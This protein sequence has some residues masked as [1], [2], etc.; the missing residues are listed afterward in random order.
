MKSTKKILAAVLFVCFSFQ[1]NAEGDNTGKLKKTN[2]S[3]AHPEYAFF[4]I[5]NVSTYFKNDGE[6][7]IRYNGNSGF[8]YPKG[9]NKAA[10]FQSGFLYGGK[11]NGEIRV[12]GSTY[13]QGQV[14]GRIISEGV[15]ENPE[16]PHVRIFRVRRDY[17]TADLSNDSIFEYGDTTQW[18][19][20]ITQVVS[21]Q[22]TKEQY[23]NDWNEWPAIYGA[24]FEDLDG[25]GIYNPE[26]DIP[27]VPGADQTIW[28]VCNDLDEVQAKLLYGSPSI[29]IEMQATIWGYKNL[30]LYNDMLFRKYKLI[31]KSGKNIED[32]FFTMWSDPDLGD[33]SDDFIGCDTAL[34]LGFVYNGD[35]RD[36]TYG[37]SIPSAG[38]M[39]LQGPLVDGSSA[40]IGFANNNIYFGKKNL[41]LS[42]FSFFIGSDPVYGDP[43]LR[44]YNGTLQIYNLM[45]GKLAFTGEPY[46]APPEAGGGVTK[47][48]LSGDPINKTGWIDGMLHTPG[49]RRIM[50]NTGPFVMAAGDTQEVIYAQIAAGANKGI[51]NLSSVELLKLSAATIKNSWYANNIVTAP[52]FPKLTGTAFDKKIVLNW[53]PDVHSQNAIEDFTNGIY[54]FEG[55]NVYQLPEINSS[56]SDY[57]LI[58]TFDKINGVGKIL[59]KSFSQK[60]NSI[61]TNITQNGND[62]GLERFLLI[63]KDY[64][65]NDYLHNGSPYYYVVSSYN[66]N[67]YNNSYLNT[68]EIYSQPIKVIPQTSNPGIQYNSKTGDK[69]E[70]AHVRGSASADVDI[71]IVN[72]AEVNGHNY[73]ISFRKNNE[74]KIIWELDDVTENITILSNQGNLSGSD[75]YIIADGIRI[76]IKQ[77]ESDPI[78]ESDL[79]RFTTPNVIYSEESAKAD[80][81]KINVFPNPY[82]GY[83]PMETQKF[84]NFVMINHLPARA[85]IRIYNLAGHLVRKLHKD[86]PSQYYLWDLQNDHNVLVASG[87]FII[88]I[89]MPDLGKVKLLKLAVILGTEV[90]DFY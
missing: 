55:Y 11:I 89:E 71:I 75:E 69:I 14:P 21:P 85:V 82:Y 26:I 74:N 65:S 19:V 81:E 38:F 5:N 46:I 60:N 42:S 53:S 80:V 68:Y 33:A 56:I 13:S 32:M 35:E 72:P 63:D 25:N 22:K 10:F 90:P 2:I 49:D 61:V 40:N 58:A 37:T 3:R 20:N 41:E 39:L 84:G 54:K 28:F 7:D 77:N 86:S 36:A 57:K 83:N 8:V 66:Y 52:H 23:S 24:P 48:A 6:S 9:S 43:V 44:E 17:R 1:L 12:G 87:L 50:M 79:Y 62:T 16:L 30:E 47:F 51:D 31:N 70:P 88:H 59:G 64:I 18:G 45:Q 34:S 15:A 78:T 29:G 76:I 67:G 27:G 73:E 4:N